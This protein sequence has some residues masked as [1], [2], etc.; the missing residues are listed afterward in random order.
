MQGDPDRSPPQKPSEKHKWT[1]AVK[2]GCWRCSRE[3]RGAGGA[4]RHNTCSQCL[5]LC[6]LIIVTLG[7]NSEAQKSNKGYLDISSSLWID[8]DLTK[9]LLLEKA[10]QQ[11]SHIGADGKYPR[12]DDYATC[13]SRRCDPR[14]PFQV[15]GWRPSLGKLIALLTQ[16]FNRRQLEWLTGLIKPLPQQTPPLAS[17]PRAASHN[18]D[19]FDLL[20]SHSGCFRSYLNFLITFNEHFSPIFPNDFKELVQDV[21]LKHT[22][23]Y[24]TVS[25]EGSSVQKEGLTIK[26]AG[27]L[28]QPAIHQLLLLLLF[29]FSRYDITAI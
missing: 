23:S 25:Q 12:T 3:I 5:E 22:H 7:P 27:C 10:D 19:L 29:F 8:T 2:T 18:F 16:A 11:T 21:L 26:I 13:P 24:Y 28:E 14:F 15:H 20:F 6:S 17:L 9:C 4:T 1:W